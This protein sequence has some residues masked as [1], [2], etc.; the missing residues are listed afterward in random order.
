[1]TLDDCFRYLDPPK[2][3]Q[4]A[5]KL[6]KLAEGVRLV[7][8]MIPAVA[9]CLV[10]LLAAPAVMAQQQA[11]DAASIVPSDHGGPSTYRVAPSGIFYTNAT[12]G[13]CILAAYQV[14]RFE[15]V[16]P[17]WLR[18]RRFDIV[19]RTAGPASKEQLMLMLQTLLGERFGVRLHWEPREMRAFALT[20]RRGGPKLTAGASNGLADIVAG[21]DGPELKNHTMP[22]LAHYLSRLPI[23]LPVVDTTGID[24]R[25]DVRI[26]L[27]PLL[28]TKK[29]ENPV[30]VDQARVELS[31]IVND[32]LRPFGLEL[33]SRMLL[34]NVIVIDQA[35]SEPT[36]N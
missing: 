3:T 24:G 4:R 13:D 10:F 14:S 19:A 35:H 18:T 29:P 6:P 31:S 8:R 11:F 25:Y 15:V 30:D 12:L 32:A 34:V 21:S 36:P 20:V 23:G 5:S 28:D 27:R 7:L 33:R 17:E 9:I 16:G 2:G 22:Q 1:M 26:T